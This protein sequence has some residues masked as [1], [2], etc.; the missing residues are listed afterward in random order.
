MNFKEFKEWEKTRSGGFLQFL[1]L[2]QFL[3]TMLIIAALTIPAFIGKFLS[4][5]NTIT[6][7]FILLFIFI[8]KCVGWILNENDYK[9]FKE[10]L[11]KS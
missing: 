5:D 1:G 4:Y 11:E 9:K 10:N 6:G 8:F 2:K 7:I 3:I